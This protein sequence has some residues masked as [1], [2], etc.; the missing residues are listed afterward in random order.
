M[1]TK[2]NAANLLVSHKGFLRL[3]N[4]TVHGNALSFFTKSIKSGT[5]NCACFFSFG[6]LL[7]FKIC[8]TFDR[9]INYEQITFSFVWLVIDKI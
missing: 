1:K 2:R 5:R 6:F 3:A 9:L 7:F 8:F 4:R